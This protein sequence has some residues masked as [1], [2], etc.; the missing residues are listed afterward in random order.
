MEG[1]A[2]LAAAKR[3]ACRLKGSVLK[4]EEAGLSSGIVRLA[5]ARR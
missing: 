4:S 1:A 2:S 3:V 5:A